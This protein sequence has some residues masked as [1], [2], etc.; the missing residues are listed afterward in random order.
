MANHQPKS[1]PFAKVALI[2]GLALI[3]LTVLILV[4]SL[5][6][7]IKRNS[8][9]GEIDTS[10]LV[11]NKS[12][13]TAANIQAIGEVATSDGAGAAPTA[14]RSG[15]D[16]Y[17]AVCAACHD[18]GAANAPKLDDKAAWEPRVATGFD[19]L[20]NTA[21]K[22]K[23][24]MPARGGQNVPD[25]ELKAAIAYMTTTAGFS[26]DAPKDEAAE[27]EPT[28]AT[29]DT[30]TADTTTTDTTTTDT[31]TTDTTTTDTAT[32]AKPEAVAAP[33]STEAEA[34]Q[35]AATTEAPESATTSAPSAPEAAT[36]PSTPEAIEAPSTPSVPTAPDAVEAP[37]TPEAPATNSEAPAPSAAESIITSTV[38]AAATTA[39][40]AA[41]TAEAVAETP[42]SGA[43]GKIIYKKTCF[44]C[45]D[46]GIA[47][48]PKIGDK[49]L[50][51]PR[52]VAGN[53]VMYESA[54][55]GKT[56]PAGAMPPKG[57]NMSLSD[58][59]VKAAVDYMVNQS[60]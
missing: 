37:S 5:I 35:P 11:A 44:A 47:G 41:T 26:L 12:T 10:A 20:M 58:D 3:L 27:K 1:D 39:A 25:G 15:E 43:D 16:V 53:D 28:E 59:E 38:A 8:I 4:N 54:L 18:T 17:Q 52:I 13:L 34:A 50:W 49:A 24:A 31:T 32:E 6:N 51:A 46:M 55:K 40:V 9:D 60:Q 42:K 36:A 21:V 48:A 33:T 22:G 30:T 2:V 14:A 29:A 7:T 57:G 23:G 45:H 19:A 56:S